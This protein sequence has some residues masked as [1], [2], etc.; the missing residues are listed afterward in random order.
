MV[1]ETFTESDTEPTLITQQTPEKCKA[2]TQ[3]EDSNID[4]KRILSLK[5]HMAVM[6]L[7]LK[8]ESDDL[9]NQIEFG[10]TGIDEFDLFFSL[11]EQI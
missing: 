4:P 10:N 6:K 3:T 8:D 5:A 9:K 11:R 2:S 1:K 7:F